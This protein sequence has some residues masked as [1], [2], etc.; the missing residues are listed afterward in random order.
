MKKR[1]IAILRDVESV[2]AVAIVET[3]IQ[4]GI[5]ELEVSLS[6]EDVGLKTLKAISET[7]GDKVRLGVGTIV[8]L[9]QLNAALNAG[10]HFVITPAFDEV[11]VNACIENHVEII[12]GVFSPSDVMKALNL[13]ITTLKLFPANALPTN[14]IKSLSGPFPKA[15]YIAVGGVTL[16]TVTDYFD[17]GFIGA[18]PGNDLVK[19]GATKDD[20]KS[21]ETKAKAYVEKC[22][23]YGS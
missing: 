20:L 23:S 21:I 11:I 18:A 19:R 16:D 13:N 2:D 22:S 6:S 7:F 3:L 8:N 17:A 4:C 5:T 12:P 9:C 14:Y 1:L 10:A 15:Q